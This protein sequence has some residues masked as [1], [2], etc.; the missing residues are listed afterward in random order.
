MLSIQIDWRVDDEK[1]RQI[2]REYWECNEE[3]QFKFKVADLAQR[4]GTKSNEVSTTVYDS[5]DAYSEDYVCARCQEPFIFKNRTS[6]TQAARVPR[7]TDLCPPCREV[8][9]A[10]LKA[11]RE[12]DLAVLK[13]KQEAE[14]QEQVNAIKKSYELYARQQPD[15]HDLTFRDAVYLL[16]FVRALYTEDLSVYGPAASS[17]F[18]LAPTTDLCVGVLNRLYERGLIRVRPDSPVDA[19]VFEDGIPSKFNIFRVKW[20][21]AT[22]NDREETRLFIQRVQSTL[23]A[24]SKVC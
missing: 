15:M 18:R 21:L 23:E 3:G 2:C 12:A 4:H 8:E 6:Y 10:T 5:C 19:F 24:I 7:K 17:I 14:R 20:A 9:Y 13:A 11:R 22:G 16:S 1:T